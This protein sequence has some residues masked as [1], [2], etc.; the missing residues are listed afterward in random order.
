MWKK[1]YAKAGIS[2][3]FLMVSPATMTSWHYGSGGFQNYRKIIKQES[4]LTGE[5]APFGGLA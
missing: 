3:R 5:I 2:T 1:A 4:G